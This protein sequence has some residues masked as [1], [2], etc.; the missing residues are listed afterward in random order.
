[1]N[2]SGPTEAVI[3]ACSVDLLQPDR[4][5]ISAWRD[6][7]E[8]E[9]VFRQLFEATRP[10]DIEAKED[11]L[12]WLNVWKVRLNKSVPV[13]VRCTAT[14]LEAQLFD[15][16]MQRDD[17]D[18]NATEIKNIYA[19]AFTRFVNYVTEE[20]QTYQQHRKRTIAQHVRGIGIEPF[21]V[22]LRH[23]CAHRSVSIAIDVF[24]RSAQYCMDWL[25][26]SYWQREL[27]TMQPVTYETLHRAKRTPLSDEFCS[28]LRAY[29][30]ATAGLLR[31]STTVQHTRSDLTDSEYKALQAEETRR[32]TDNLRVIAQHLLAQFVRNQRTI[33]HNLTGVRKVCD[34]VMANCR[35]LM[36]DPVRYRQGHWGKLHSVFFRAL[37]ET[38]CLQE[39]FERL[40]AVAESDTEDEQD[41]SMASFWTVKIATGFQLLKE[42][43]RYCR[44]L[45][46]QRLVSFQELVNGKAKRKLVA[47][48][49]AQEW[50]QQKLQ[51]LAPQHLILGLTVD[52]PWRLRLDRRQLKT[53]L[54]AINPHTR[55]L[56]P[57]LFTL[58]EPPLT[59]AHQQHLCT[60][61]EIYADSWRQTGGGQQTAGSMPNYEQL[62]ASK[63]YAVQDVIERLGR[64]RTTKKC[65][66]WEAPDEGLDWDEYPLGIT[67]RDGL[68]KA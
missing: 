51:K 63:T 58:V 26:D 1:M 49:L 11:A 23:L 6:K 50:Y 8:F 37:A 65:G 20:T 46:T 16:R 12:Q 15:L 41:R 35:Y 53:H 54:N 3:P 52:C 19:G 24:R 44:T 43:K 38:G 39:L 31:K 56:L 32:G 34:A 28:V 57:I 48:R 36:Q 21:L 18:P 25:K 60:M 30:A 14:V 45:H 27:N 33:A 59:A 55:K 9:H 61:I 67:R 2:E 47:E 62:L 10:E 22:E 17:G 7:S 68:C 5:H 66:L 64:G 29:D 13:C 40:L 4:T 42:F